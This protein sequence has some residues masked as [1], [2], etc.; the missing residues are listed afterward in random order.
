MVI[1]EI[2]FLAKLRLSTPMTVNWRGWNSIKDFIHLLIENFINC[3]NS[4]S[5]DCTSTLSMF[6][7]YLGAILNKNHKIHNF[8]DEILNFLTN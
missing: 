3:L 6:L 7:Q 2:I 8:F 1:I 5:S 4:I